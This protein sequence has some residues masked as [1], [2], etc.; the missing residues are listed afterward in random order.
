MKAIRT[1]HFFETDFNM[2][3]CA[4]NQKKTNDEILRKCQK[5]FFTAY[6]WHFS[7]RKIFLSKIGLGHILDI[8][9]LHR[10][11]KIHKKIFSTAREVKKIPFFRRKSAVAGTTNKCNFNFRKFWLQ[12]S[13]L[14]TI[15]PC[16]MVGI[17]I[18]NDM[19]LCGKTTKYKEKV[20]GKSAKTAISGIFPAF[21]TGK[22][23]FL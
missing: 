8:A 20:W 4:K 16:L 1:A 22:R 21:L 12:K 10:C 9:I 7:A 3:L 2:H 15:E 13:V 11:A 17:I 6:F 5:P 18:Y 23:F 14:L 19:F